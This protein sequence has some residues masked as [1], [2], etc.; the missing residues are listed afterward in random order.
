[1]LRLVREGE[2]V[3]FPFHG[4][5]FQVRKLTHGKGA[6]LRR[7]NT[8]KG[9]V[10]E[11]ALEDAVWRW[12]LAGWTDLYDADGKPVAYSEKRI[13]AVVSALPP[14]IVDALMAVARS[15]EVLHHEAGKTS[16]PSSGS[17]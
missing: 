10:N 12:I 8:E 7:E 16:S 4:S 9:R 1:M 14:D 2:I 17:A 15:P 6:D 3:D 11:E 5:T 13:P